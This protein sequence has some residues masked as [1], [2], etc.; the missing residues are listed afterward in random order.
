MSMPRCYFLSSDL[1]TTCQRVDGIDDIQLAAGYVALSLSKERT[2]TH[3]P[4]LVQMTHGHY[5]YASL[6]WDEL[7]A[8][9]ESMV[10]TSL[11][12]A[13][14][15]SLPAGVIQL[16]TDVD[17]EYTAELHVD[18]LTMLLSY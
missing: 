4:I 14:D 8:I 16:R 9:V 1:V 10:D 18:V 13:E 15:G 3:F 5:T 7:D 12:F 11:R 2:E 6:L 17:E